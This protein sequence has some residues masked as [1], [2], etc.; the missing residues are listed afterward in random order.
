[1]KDFILKLIKNLAH[2][3]TIIGIIVSIAVPFLVYL[4]PNVGHKD[5]IKQLDLSL[6]FPLF[7]VQFIAIVALFCSLN[8]DFREWVK[9]ILPNKAFSILTIV[10]A[11]AISIFAAT[12]IEARHR[13]QSDE[14]VFMSVAQNI[15]Y[16]Q[17]S[18]TCNQGYY[19][20]GGL[21][22]VS[23]SNSFKTKGLAFLYVLGMPLFGT[24]L[25]WIF[26]AELLMLPL[27]FLLMFLAIV[28]WTRQP[29]LAFFAALLTALQP[30]VL[31]QFRSM[32][33]EPLYIFLSALSLFT[34]K[35][36]YDRNTVRHWAI[37]ALVLAFFAQ[38]RQETV[39]CFFPFI[40]F[41]LPK[42]LDQKS[43]KAPTFFVL[44]S[45]FSVPVLLTISYFQ[46]FGFQ[47]GE[48]EAHGHFLEDLSK[49]WEIMTRALRKNGELANPFLTY[50]N[51]LFAAG[52]IYLI[53]RAIYDATKGKNPDSRFFYLKVL[54]FLALYH[55]QTYVILENVSGDFSIEINQRYSL[56]MIPSMAFLAA[57]PVAHIADYLAKNFSDKNKV[58]VASAILVAS[59]IALIF[60]GWTAHY[61]SDFNKNIMYNRNHLTIEEYEILGWLKEQPQK[62]R[63]FIYGRPWHFVGYGVSSI[64]YDKA[65]QMNSRELQK[66]VD[67]YEGEVYY[68]RGLDCWDSQTYHKKAVEHR[69]ATTC[70]VFERDM[71]MEGIKNILITNN[72]WVQIAK[73]KGRKNYNVANIIAAMEPT[74]I[75]EAKSEKNLHEVDENTDVNKIETDSLQ[76]N[77]TLKETSAAARKWQVAVSINDKPVLNVPYE[78]GSPKYNVSTDTLQPGFN[79]IRYVVASRETGKAVA[80]AIQN[81]FYPVNGAV[82]LN[83]LQPSSHRQGWGT[84]HT[85][86]SIEGHTFTIDGKRYNQ[87]F[88]THAA[89]ETDFDLSGKYSTFRGSV[90]L[91]DE[92][93]CSEGVSVEVYGDGQLLTKTSSF[94]NGEL[95]SLNVK[96]AGVQKLKIKSIPTG[97][98]DCT[99][100]DIVNA[101]L[102]P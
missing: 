57:L 26:N 86:E 76:L 54:A 20:N 36:A 71:E 42:L 43:A 72:Y 49:N 88:G 12:Q 25:R 73:F 79:Q 60:S 65:R 44:L 85:N 64:H 75:A 70:D 21:E 67:S 16:N 93:L 51:Y 82:A 32:S 1:M 62:D 96:T 50:F 80:T 77:M 17:E 92:S 91:D 52:L 46:G 81:Y 14:S 94:K 19:K 15:Y 28:A 56:V 35:W 40:L 90:G 24:D 9:G 33:V 31:F 78:V 3:G 98:I 18:G 63:L 11:V 101:A 89:S 68:I 8:K 2:P 66:L 55:L 45:I 4:G 83:T 97:S 6:P 5:T 29:L 84:L 47:G 69:I 61:K 13:V 7:C 27:T 10:F 23:K 34:F 30:T 59:V 58:S 39:F 48:F 95:V 87:G 37:A 22:C 99:H 102:I 100:V 53:F 38:T 74:L 41:A